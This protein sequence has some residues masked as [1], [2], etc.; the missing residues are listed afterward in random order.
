MSVEDGKMFEFTP[1]M[2]A[3][4][5]KSRRESF[6]KMMKELPEKDYEIVE[7]R[8]EEGFTARLAV[9]RTYEDK[10]GMF[11][12]CPGG[13]FMFKS[14]NEALPVA[15]FFYEKGVNVA[16]L[17]YHVSQEEFPT[18][19]MRYEKLAGEDGLQAIRY[20]RANAEKYN[21]LPDRIA[22]GGFSAGGMLSA[23][24]ATQFDYGDPTAADPLL[25]ISSRP[26]AALILY[27]AFSMTS[28]V[29]PATGGMS[30]EEIAEANKLDN[31]RNIRVD[32]P[33][34]FVFQTHGD[35]PRIALN[36]CM[37]LAVH[38]VPYEIHTFEDGPHGGGL[39]NGKDETPDIPHTAMWASIAADWL[40][41][42]GF[43][44]E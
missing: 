37:E 9:H 31:I 21:L 15:D 36:F 39:Y 22:I 17:D 5:V 24:A 26:D 43:F 30:R 33:P 28:S 13:G 40:R 8:E 4:L 7:L 20:L 41:H 18:M 19:E 23:Y 14:W 12:I 11:I 44:E 3:G 10:R 38:G 32:C 35:D 16:I 2:F 6:A 1:E 25:R 27:G 34:M 42:H 29:P